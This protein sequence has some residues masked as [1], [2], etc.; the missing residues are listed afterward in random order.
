MLPLWTDI[1]AGTLIQTTAVLVLGLT[2]M[3]MHLFSP[4]GRV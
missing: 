3:V 4:A 1:D 2:F